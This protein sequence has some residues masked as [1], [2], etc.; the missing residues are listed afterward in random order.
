MQTE[1]S[2]DLFREDFVVRFP[3]YNLG[4]VGSKPNRGTNP[5]HRFILVERVAKSWQPWVANV[6]HP[7]R[8]DPQNPSNQA[9]SWPGQARPESA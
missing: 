1:C 3:R 5:P 7:V 9:M 8:R 2:A 4:R 6:L